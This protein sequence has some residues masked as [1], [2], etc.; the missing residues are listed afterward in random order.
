MAKK[1]ASKVAIVTG[2]SDGIGAAIAKALAAAGASVVV[3]YNSN[4][5][6]GEA[7]VAAIKQGGGNAVAIGADISRKDPAQSLVAAAM[8]TYGRLDI[9]VNNAGV[10]DF[11]PFDDFTEDLYRR[12]FDT[13]VLGTFLVTA[14]ALKHLGKGASIINIGSVATHFAPPGSAVYTATKS[15]I[16]GFTS[17]LAN[18]LGP[19]GIRVNALKPGM[20]ATEKSV[21][22][23]I[24]ESDF[25]K[26]FIAQTP[27]GRL[28]T[29]QEMGNAAVFLASEDSS[30]ITGDH[31]LVAGGLR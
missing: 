19:R 16:D 12:I 25:A 6:G 20:T 3:N 23:D 31:M 28:G 10:A 9:L 4:K 14:A 26:A 30:F 27:L 13:N 24:T 15:A 21:A 18:E 22:A 8:A 11:V 1:L 7:V 29:T 17:V 2:S 5:A